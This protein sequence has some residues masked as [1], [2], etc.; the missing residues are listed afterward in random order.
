MTEFLN[1]G[2]YAAYIWPAYIISA[3]CLIALLLWSLR[4]NAATS[5]RLALLEEGKSIY[6]KKD[7]SA[8]APAPAS[9]GVTA[10]TEGEAS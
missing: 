2:G 10:S 4:D 9:E 3:A 6:E 1:M 5:R 8:P 7:Q